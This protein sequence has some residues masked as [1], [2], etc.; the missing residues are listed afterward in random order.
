M[1]E[2]SILGRK[3]RAFISDD[4]EEDWDEDYAEDYDSDPMNDDGEVTTRRITGNPK[5]DIKKFTLNFARWIKFQV[6]DKGGECEFV[7]S[8]MV[9]FYLLSSFPS[10]QW[11]T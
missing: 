6:Y 11:L 2:F 8:R 5:K 7:G 4:D 1:T 3:R 9:S 10:L